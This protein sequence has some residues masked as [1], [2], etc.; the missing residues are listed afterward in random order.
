MS[1][2]GAWCLLGRRLCVSRSTSAMLFRYLTNTSDTY[3]LATI[4]RNPSVPFCT[5]RFVRGFEF[6]YRIVRRCSRL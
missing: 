3:L 1:S 6:V 5:Y 4:S 2:C